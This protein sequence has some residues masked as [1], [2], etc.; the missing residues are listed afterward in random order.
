MRSKK[1]LTRLLSSIL[2]LS[3]SAQAQTLLN[4]S[5]DP[6]VN[7][8]ANSIRHLTSTGRPKATKLLLSSS[9]MAVPASRPAPSL[10]A[11]LPT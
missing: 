6:P 3:V 7:F 2:L 4:V 1:I 5:Y 9:P 11:C 10:T 8:T